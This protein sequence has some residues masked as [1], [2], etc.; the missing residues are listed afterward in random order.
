M[1]SVLCRCGTK[2]D[3]H[4]GDIAAVCPGCG[5]VYFNEPGQRPLTADEQ[6]WKCPVC[7]AMNERYVDG[8]PTEKCRSCGQ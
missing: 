1:P 6:R 2:F 8:L 7:G 3:L 5:R 4:Y